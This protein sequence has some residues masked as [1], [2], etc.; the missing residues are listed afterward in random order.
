MLLC[1][2]CKWHI[3]IIIFGPAFKRLQAGIIPCNIFLQ[4]DV[5]WCPA[6]A[7]HVHFFLFMFFLSPLSSK[8]NIASAPVSL[9][10]APCSL[11][12]SL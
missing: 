5:T 7:E 8:T 4:K 10:S 3:I 2:Q 6:F 11:G 12:L 1:A 9:H